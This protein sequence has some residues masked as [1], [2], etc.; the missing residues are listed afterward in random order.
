MRG[1]YSPLDSVRSGQNAY[2]PRGPCFLNRLSSIPTRGRDGSYGNPHRICGKLGEQ[3]PGKF[4]PGPTSDGLSAVSGKTLL[5]VLPHWVLLVA[6]A[7]Q[8]G[9]FRL[10]GTFRPFG[11]FAH[12]VRCLY[13]RYVR[14]WPTVPAVSG[15]CST[16]G[17]VR[18]VEVASC[19]RLGTMSTPIGILASCAAY[20]R[21][22][23]RSVSLGRRVR[24]QGF[25]KM[26][27]A[28]ARAD[29]LTPTET[30]SD[31]A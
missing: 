3:T 18:A 9:Q 19:R 21:L 8:R 6:H 27:R 2:L 7:F 30:N 28:P 1:P 26:G 11:A 15:R 5:P 29:A 10:K 25:L 17:R 20:T 22:I 23:L 31:T 13:G 16:P 24:V 4:Y 14:P 12:G